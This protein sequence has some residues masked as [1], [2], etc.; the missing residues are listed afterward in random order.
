MPRYKLTVEYDGRGFHGW[1]RAAGL[2]TIQ[3]ALEDALMACAAPAEVFVSGRTDAGVHARGQVAHVD[4]VKQWDPFTLMQAVNFHLG[5]ARI[6]VVKVEEVADDFHARFSA[7]RRHYLYRILNRRA[8]AGL[9]E[10]YVW[11]IPVML[12]VARMQDAAQRMLG[13]HDF[14]SFRAVGCQSKSAI[15][16][17]D[18]IRVERVGEEVHLHLASRSFLY[19]QVRITAGTLAMVGKG[20]WEPERVSEL[21]EQKDR[22][23]AGPTAVAGG[24]Y[25]MKVDY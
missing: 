5:E 21:L 2:P 18:E 7:K 9:D 14:S 17:M 25:F 23:R 13:T 20:A 12:D 19:N 24:L 1:Q 10:G 3:Q 11:H 22:A 6:S 15:K 4:L 16:T 8:R